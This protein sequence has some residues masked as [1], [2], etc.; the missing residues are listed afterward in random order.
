[1]QHPIFENWDD[2]NSLKGSYE[3][4]KIFCF[5]EKWEAKYLRE[6]IKRH[7]PNLPAKQIIDAIAHCGQT[8]PLPHTRMFFVKG[9]LER[10]GFK[11]K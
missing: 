8:L 6:K 4:S 11:I 2:Y 7:Y 9:V 5:Q 10:L 1:M 3:E